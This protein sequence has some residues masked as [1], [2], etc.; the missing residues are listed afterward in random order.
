LGN[1]IIITVR[2]ESGSVHPS[3]SALF[4]PNKQNTKHHN[5]SSNMM[6]RLLPLLLLLLIVIIA[7]TVTAQPGSDKA[8]CEIC[9]CSFCPTGFTMTKPT[10]TLTITQD[11][12]DEFG[13]IPIPGGDGTQTVSTALANFGI[14]AG[15]AIPC[16]ALDQA[17][18]TGIIPVEACI[19]ELRLNPLIRDTCGC[20]AV[21][22]TTGTNTTTAAPPTSSPAGLAFTTAPVAATTGT[23]TTT[24]PPPVMLPATTPGGQ[25]PM[26]SENT[27]NLPLLTIIGAQGTLTDSDF[28]LAK[29]TGDCNRNT[30][31]DGNLE[32]FSRGGATTIPGCF[33][34]ADKDGTD[35]CWDPND[36]PLV[37]VIAHVGSK[38]NPAVYFP[39]QRCTGQCSNDTECATGLVCLFRDKD[40]DP[41]YG[42]D[43][44][45]VDRTEYCVDPNDLP[46]GVNNNGTTTTTDTGVT[47]TPT[48]T[49]MNSTDNTNITTTTNTTMDSNSTLA[50]SSAMP[51]T[52]FPPPTAATVPVSPTNSN[53]AQPVP[54]PPTSNSSSPGR[55]L[56]TAAWGWSCF[57]TAIVIAGGVASL[58]V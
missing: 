30:D 46:G 22:L 38:G 15:A 7:P 2:A 47:D 19:D 57:A 28:P 44:P 54:K 24:S 1:S 25:E 18:V 37:G 49:P 40:T 21:P 53:A 58:A 5:R 8:V 26:V 48:M 42:C 36:K 56:N 45:L 11:I 52:T 4:P 3:F 17:A 14:T 12:L 23:G 34:R 31:C 50:P 35:Y 41:V 27:F 33:G 51:N 43:G 6:S 13:A 32:C 55:M 16:S 9:G 20:P 39:L 29:C 10:E